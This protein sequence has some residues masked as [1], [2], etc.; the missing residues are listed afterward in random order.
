[1]EKDGLMGSVEDERNAAFSSVSAINVIARLTP[2]LKK[3]AYG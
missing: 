1:V 3:M 2:A